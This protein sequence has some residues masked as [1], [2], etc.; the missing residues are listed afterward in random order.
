MLIDLWKN[1]R[2]LWDVTFGNYG[3]LEQRKSALA[4]IKSYEV[5][6]GQATD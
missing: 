3:N 6:L 4:R 2:A 5:K 1:E